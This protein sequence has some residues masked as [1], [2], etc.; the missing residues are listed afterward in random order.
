M[1]KLLYIATILIASC[2]PS[3][4]ATT[5]TQRSVNLSVVEETSSA[6]EHTIEAT[7][8][9][10]S[11]TETEQWTVEFISDTTNKAPPEVNISLTEDGIK[12]TGAMPSSVSYTSSKTEESRE[13]AEMQAESAWEERVINLNQDENLNVKVEEKPTKDPKRFRHILLTVIILTTIGIFLRI[14]KSNVFLK[15]FK[16]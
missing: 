2:G 9:E 13:T 4:V 11:K 7:I 5:T 6:V 15:L 1:R 10:Q 8:T 3:K 12:I 16:R 14:R